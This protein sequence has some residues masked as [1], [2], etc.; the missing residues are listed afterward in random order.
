M[1]P[2]VLR[3]L[4][5]VGSQPELQAEKGRGPG[6]FDPPICARPAVRR[7]YGLNGCR[8][9]FGWRGPALDASW[10][11]RGLTASS[12]LDRG[13][14]TLGRPGAPSLRFTGPGET[15]SRAFTPLPGNGCR[16]PCR[17]R[18]SRQG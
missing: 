4:V 5:R 9:V 11:L 14:G 10:C 7:V 13:L 3:W 8:G 12:R 1:R 17:I 15:R 16:N 6:Q 2:W 18:L